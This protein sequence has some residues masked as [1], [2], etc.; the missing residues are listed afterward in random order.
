[1]VDAFSSSTPQI[2]QKRI[3]PSM[4]NKMKIVVNVILNI[5]HHCARV[6]S[7]LQICLLASSVH[8]HKHISNFFVSLCVYNGYHSDNTIKYCASRKMFILMVQAYSVYIFL[9]SV[10]P[11]SKLLGIQEN[12]S[13]YRWIMFEMSQSPRMFE[14]QCAT[15]SFSESINS[16]V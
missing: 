2:L 16:S 11:M 15:T 1:M 9:R 8:T 13:V 7:P 12:Q 14:L 5:F 4:I 3:A 10:H 6:C